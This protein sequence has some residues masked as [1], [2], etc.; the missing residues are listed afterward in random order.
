MQ[1]Y[2]TFSK[3][4]AL[5]QVHRKCIQC[6]ICEEKLG[7]RPCHSHLAFAIIKILSF[8]VRN[9]LSSPGLNYLLTKVLSVYLER[10][11]RISPE[12][13]SFSKSTIW[14]KFESSQ[15]PFP[16]V[17]SKFGT[18]QQIWTT[19]KIL[20]VKE[21][22]GYLIDT[23]LD[24]KTRVQTTFARHITGAHCEGYFSV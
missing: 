16:T 6:P 21:Q 13:W 12:P 14:L 20:L 4:S 2:S 7:V 3:K 10:K 17:P 24:Q 8:S 11:S 22:T 5:G 1:F 18:G 19:T 9:R 23:C 15:H